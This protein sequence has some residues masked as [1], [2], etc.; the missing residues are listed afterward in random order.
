MATSSKDRRAKEILATL[1]AREIADCG[2]SF[3]YFVF[4]W[5]KTFDPHDKVNP[6]KHFPDKATFV[7]SQGSSSTGTMCS[8]S[9]RAVS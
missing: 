4:K 9:P 5:A 2:E 8:T 7:T 1:E 3:E 6:V